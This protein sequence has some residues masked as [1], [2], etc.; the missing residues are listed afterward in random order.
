MNANQN[1][2]RETFGL[3]ILAA[4]LAGVLLYYGYLIAH[5]VLMPLFL[6]IGSQLAKIIDPSSSFVF[7]VIALLNI[8]YVTVA[9][10]LSSVVALPLLNYV[11]RPTAMLVPS[12]SMAVFLLLSNWWFFVRSSSVVKTEEPDILFLKHLA[13]LCVVGVFWL[14]SWWV[15]KRNTANTRLVD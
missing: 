14:G 4:A 10:A 5:T 3:A 11:L 6:G 12:I 15:V 8:S 13:P 7:L 9:G 2:S 1:R